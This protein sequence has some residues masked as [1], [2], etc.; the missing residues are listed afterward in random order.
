MHQRRM[1]DLRKIPGEAISPT[2]NTQPC[3]ALLDFIKRT[4]SH[5]VVVLFCLGIHMCSSDTLI[6]ATPLLISWSPS[7]IL[8]CTLCIWELHYIK[9]PFCYLYCCCR[10]SAIA[11]DLPPVF[12]RTA[13]CPGQTGNI[14]SQKYERGRQRRTHFTHN[15]GR[16]PRPS[17]LSTTFDDDDDHTRSSS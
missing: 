16:R 9:F 2:L 1:A 10:C 8:C 4:L 6:P 5:R 12:D 17:H 14:M 3:M 7:R 11:T 13:V 15:D